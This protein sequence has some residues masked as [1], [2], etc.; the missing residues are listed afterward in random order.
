MSQNPKD[1]V[2]S[3]G[4]PPRPVNRVG[5]AVSSARKE[6]TKSITTTVQPQQG[7]VDRF[8]NGTRE[9]ITT[10][11]VVP[12][13][14][15]ELGQMELDCQTLEHQSSRLARQDELEWVQ[16]YGNVKEQEVRCLG[17]EREAAGIRLELLDL[18]LNYDA[19]QR[20]WPER[21]AE[22]LAD[23]QTKRLVAE[24][25]QVRAQAELLKAQQE[26]AALQPEP[27]KEIRA[28]QRPFGE[29][30]SDDLLRSL[31]QS[32]TNSAVIGAVEPKTWDDRW[33]PRGG[34]T[35]IER[36]MRTQDRKLAESDTYA[37][38][39]HNLRL[40]NAGE[41]VMDLD[42]ARREYQHF[43]DLEEQARKMGFL[44]EIRTTFNSYNRGGG[45]DVFT[46]SNVT[47]IDVEQRR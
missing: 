42:Q 3:I 30:K 6:F 2:R 26:Y 28:S 20:L 33:L 27:K 4:I 34:S 22:A 7:I 36:F 21:E 17:Y 19:A 32:Y 43:L 12:L 47:P 5:N 41:L 37:S 8:L 39:L 25:R 13:T 29:A 18:H 10:T 16:H 14:S 38:I 35:F 44:D 9:P 24:T 46:R 1:L 23:I 40:E 15:Y 31:A 11:T 45:A